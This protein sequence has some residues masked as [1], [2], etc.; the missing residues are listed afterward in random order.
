MGFIF[1][2]LGGAAGGYIISLIPTRTDFPVLT[3]ITNITGAILIGFIAG[4]V[5]GGMK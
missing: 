3:L 1:V 5:S 2:A 4:I